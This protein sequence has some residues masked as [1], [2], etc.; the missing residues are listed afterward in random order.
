M[1]TTS[2]LYAEKVFAEHPTAL[3]SLGEEIDYI[4]LI[5]EPQRDLETWTSSSTLISVDTVATFPSTPFPNSIISKIT[6]FAPSSQLHTFELS[7]AALPP[8]AFDPTGERQTFNLGVFVYADHVY[9]SGYEIG[10]R[11][12]DPETSQ[13][14]TE[15]QYFVSSISG[16]W[17]HLSHT[18]RAPNV[19]VDI[20][21][22]L[23]ATYL[24]GLYTS[25]DYYVN[26]L[27]VGQWSEE[28]AVES[29]GINAIPDLQTITMTPSANLQ[30]IPAN[31]YGLISNPGYYIYNPVSEQMACKNTSIPMTYGSLNATKLF[32]NSLNKPSFIL[33]SS[34]MLSK[35]GSSD[36][37]TLE[38]W[39]RVNEIDYS[40]PEDFSTLLEITPVGVAIKTDG[41]FLVL[42]VNDQKEKYF[43]GDWAVPRLFD[44][45]ISSSVAGLMI[46][47]ETVISIELEQSPLDGISL[48]DDSVTNRWVKF[49][50]P[51]SASSVEID[52]PAIYSYKVPAVVAK[53]RFAFGQAVDSP[54]GSNR[55]FG[56]QLASIDYKFAD[57]TNSYNYPD[58]GKWNQ[59]ILENL[60]V[61]QGALSIPEYSAPQVVLQSST[62]TEWLNDQ[63]AEVLSFDGNPGY[64]YFQDFNLLKNNMRA[65]YTIFEIDAFSTNEKIIF[66]IE[67][68]SNSN[69]FQVSL[70]DENIVY[71]FKYGSS[72][73]STLYSSS[74]VTTNTPI[75]TG[76]N[77]NGLSQYFGGNVAA[78]FSDINK[79]QLYVAGQPSFQNTFDGTISKIGFCTTKNFDK[80]SS[81]F[82]TDEIDFW[83]LESQVDAGEEYFGNSAS[84]WAAT[85][86]G[87]LPDSFAI[88]NIV[89]HVA[90]YTLH[91]GE[92][93]RNDFLKI[94]TDSYWEDHLPLSYFAQYVQDQFGEFYYD[95]D[96]IQFNSSY[97]AIP[98]FD[99]AYYDTDSYLVKTY[100]TFQ[101][102]ST[103]ANAQAISFSN[104][105]RVPRDSVII[106]DDNWITTRYEVVDGSI[107]YPPVGVD[108]NSLAIVTSLEIQVDNAITDKLVLKRLEYASQAFNDKTANPIGTKFGISVFP[109][110]KYRAYYDYKA[111]NPYRIYK[112]STPHL[113][114][115]RDSGIEL[116]GE[117]DT[118]LQRGFL[119][120]INPAAAPEYKVIGLQMFMRS[121]QEFFSTSSEL[122]FEIQGTEE[123]VRFFIEAIEPSGKRARI[124]GL[125]AK[126]GASENGIAYY[127]NGKLVREPVVNI[128]EWFSLGIA[129]AKPFNFNEVVGAV[130]FM[131]PMLINNIAHYES[132]ALQ[133][134]QRQSKRSWFAVE[135]TYATWLNVLRTPFGGNYNWDDILVISSRSYFGIDPKSIYNTYVGTNKIV[136]DDNSKMLIGNANYEIVSNVEWQSQ[137]Y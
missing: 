88:G 102:L 129:F 63:T 78:F 81:Y 49:Y 12:T 52:C 111:R 118:L 79:L 47:G 128:D 77:I 112:G 110:V 18:F 6:A 31:A 3:W 15:S 136:I 67:D 2:N 117:N 38:F 87:G 54:E 21:I 109:F 24:K 76:I 25:V 131:G 94:A 97:R 62:F 45:Y 28:F 7:K 72:A 60:T 133:E 41:L 74:G 137:V 75:F 127:I 39:M 5:S 92:T 95:L 116:L 105:E 48:T 66:K 59:G 107:I 91:F 68:R 50:C 101:Y 29:L 89:D 100:I 9:N 64:L 56:G 93:N 130:R 86:D 20:T 10:Y 32:R 108:I 104:T 51:P 90:S 33:P 135:N 106:P 37:H 53:R 16:Q 84:F 13:V 34:G 30:G 114:L 125:N 19:G 44:L 55:S 43:I 122:L 124:Y 73:V 71:K 14:V 58:I 115:T 120:P 82:N 26:G 46:N 132:S 40:A 96:F 99:G 8:N 103:G 11:Y 65:L 119:I 17:L 98:K 27:S 23:K 22:F 126:T 134:I 42:E 36:F 61:S 35:S 85:L 1:S 4:S 80:I 121:N 69:Y 57:Y 70:V 123:Y 113:Y 83:V